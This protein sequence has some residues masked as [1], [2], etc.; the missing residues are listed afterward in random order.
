ML[1]I[2]LFDRDNILCPEWV[3]NEFLEEDWQDSVYSYEDDKHTWSLETSFKNVKITY[4]GEEYHF[5]AYT[6]DGEVMFDEV[7]T[8][9]EIIQH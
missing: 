1:V 2:D 7:I 4:D 9:D 5:I 3:S 8:K 6:E